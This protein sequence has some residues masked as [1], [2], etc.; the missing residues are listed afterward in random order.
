MFFSIE[1]AVNKTYR[2]KLEH[3]EWLEAEIEQ[4]NKQAV[5]LGCQPARLHY[6]SEETETGKNP[7]TGIEYTITYK[8]ISVEGEA[9]K[10]A[11]WK[12]LAAI[13]PQESGENFVSCVPG[14]TVPVEYR[15]TG[16][17]CDHCGASRRR[18]EIFVLGNEDGRF[19]QIGRNCLR[20]FLGGKSPEGILACA[21]WGFAVA[22]AAGQAEGDEFFGGGGCGGGETGYNL[23]EFVKTAAAVIRKLGWVS[24]SAVAS[25]EFGGGPAPTA[26]VVEWLLTP[27]RTDKERREVQKFI[28]KHDF[29]LEER[30]EKLAIDALAWGNALPTDQGDYLFN[31]GVACRLGFV[32]RKTV[33]IV[34]SLIAAYQRHLDREA[35][36]RV[37]QQQNKKRI[38]LGFVGE[39]CGF[40]QV[41]IKSIRSF[42]SDF[43]VRTMIRFEDASG[44]VLVWW[45][46][47]DTDWEEGQTLDIT[48]TVKKHEDWKGI[49]Q[50]ILQ[51]VKEGLPKKKKKAA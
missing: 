42:D 7:V 16:L 8:V 10:F 29:K 4:L 15:T 24:R 37:Q 50:T 35:E 44:S 39:R 33:G 18:K 51:R 49:P 14:E 38:H 17:H 28:D 21:A 11:G 48:G 1:A 36:L 20:D 41:T 13:E 32:R 31:L 9:P 25:F 23:E 40:E 19:A 22:D 3:I 34:A 12:L 2:V 30:D 46:S 27:P 6:H 5:K 47:G 45:K 43:G 26:N